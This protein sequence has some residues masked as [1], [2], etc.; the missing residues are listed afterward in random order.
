M[1]WLS[2]ISSVTGIISFVVSFFDYFKKWRTYLLYFAFLMG[3]LTIGVI[4]SMSEQTVQQFTQ[5]QLI[6]LIALVTLVGLLVLFIYRFLTHANEPLFITIIFL[7]L[8]GWFTLRILN[9]V[10]SSQSFLKPNDYLI[11]SNHYD[12]TGD[13]TKAADFLKK[14]RDLQTQH[15]PDAMLD[16]IDI[17]V[18]KLYYKGL[19]IKK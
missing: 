19:G 12:S 17:K 2:I 6:Y 15:L 8:A 16:S 11:I 7:V 14:Y 4:L 13:Y 5:A 18:N 9:T 1:F 3:G 10:E